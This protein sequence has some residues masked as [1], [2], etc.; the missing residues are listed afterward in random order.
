[1][2]FQKLSVLLFCFISLSNCAQ[3]NDQKS[4]PIKS[5]ISDNV[6]FSKTKMSD[7]IRKSYA[8]SDY[9]SENEELNKYVD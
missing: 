6:E 4:S 5:N 7:T 8:L 1:M 9:L 3:E 2:T